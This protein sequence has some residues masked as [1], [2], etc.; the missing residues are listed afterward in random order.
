MWR[1]CSFSPYGT[2]RS[3]YGT[4]I[5][6]SPCNIPLVPMGPK[7]S[8]VSQSEQ[9][10]PFIHRVLKMSQW[11]QMSYLSPW[12]HHVPCVIMGPNYIIKPKC[13]SRP[14]GTKMSHCPME[15]N[16]PLVHIGPKCNF[17][18][19]GPKC[20]FKYPWDQNVPLC[21]GSK[22]PLSLGHMRQKCPC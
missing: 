17:V 22:C 19:V 12:D 20:P 7:M 18:P 2:R 3:M 6:F 15:T 9:N 16:V 8:L 1:K 21:M 13:H 14:N 4:K 11:D 10:V 5:G